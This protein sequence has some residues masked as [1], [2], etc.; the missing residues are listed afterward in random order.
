MG[1][2]T[3]PGA[4]TGELTTPTGAALVRVLAMRFADAPEMTAVSVGHG[5]GSRET[6]TANV[7]RIVV[8]ESAATA[9]AVP[10]SG[11]TVAVADDLGVSRDRVAVVRAVVDHISAEH[12]AFALDTMLE[13]GARDAWIAPIVM[14]KG[15]PGNEITVLADP[16]D[17]ERLARLLIR[18]TGTLGVRVGESERIVAAREVFAV[19]TEF[20]P[21]RVKRG[22]DTV[23]RPEHDD[24]ARIARE[25]DLTLAEVEEAVRRALGDG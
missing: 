14:K 9:T 12:L 15:R 6:E 7:L 11:T 21:V 4:S 1:V 16:G 10:G 24:C 2:P 23:T 18:H 3:I 19:D 5:A 13:A 8:G 25:R 22:P 20:G 17:A